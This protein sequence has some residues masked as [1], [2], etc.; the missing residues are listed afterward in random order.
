M[1]VSGLGAV[2]LWEQDVGGSNPSA[3]TSSK[4]VTVP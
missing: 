2:L 4:Y 1:G 3:P